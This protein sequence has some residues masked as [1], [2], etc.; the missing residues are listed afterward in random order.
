M[1]VSVSKDNGPVPA[2]PTGEAGNP[3]HVVT[4]V[5]EEAA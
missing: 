4:V 3:N 1:E 2:V 5:L